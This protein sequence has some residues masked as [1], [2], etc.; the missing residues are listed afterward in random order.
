[1]AKVNPQLCAE[2]RE[3]RLQRTKILLLLLAAVAGCASDTPAV[4]ERPTGGTLVISVGGDPETL[5]PPLATTTP[6]QIIGDLVY[7][8]LAEIGDSL[9][10]TG[11]GGYRPRLASSW[12]WAADSMSIGFH[13][14]PRARWH[15][16]NPVRA[17]DV[18]F[19][20][21]IYS[22]PINGSP[23]A[24]A[25]T[26]IDSVVARDSLTA[27][28][29]F[30]S[31]SPNQF[32]D[33]VGTMYIL[34][35]H[36]LA[37]IR[38]ADLRTSSLA[39][40]PVGTGRFRFVKWAAAQS[41][42]LAADTGN[43]RG[44][45]NLDRVI[46]TIAPDFNTALARLL[47]GEADV[48]EQVP[49]V[50]LHEIQA[51]KSIAITLTPGLEYFFLQL[52]LRSPHDRRRPH[53]LF[54]DRALRRALTM[55]VDRNSV[56]RSAYG[57]LAE[58]A[59]GPTVRAYPTTDTTLVQIPFSPASAARTLDSLGWKDTN[60][61]GVRD[62]RD[63]PLEF[64]VEVPASSKARNAMAVIIQEQL[65]QVGVKMNIDRVDFAAFI[66]REEKRDFDAVLGGW[67]VEASPG[68]VRQTWGSIG[69]RQ[70]GGTNYG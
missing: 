70:A 8:H 18:A 65:R 1:M 62:R 57:P 12:T 14:D 63:G 33:A 60:G 28:F 22:N 21:Q 68:S 66:D 13:I 54:A 15:D 38:G 43:Y 31:R 45:P 55:A 67:H 39:R 34:P 52:N 16:G 64:D 53:R 40:A 3:T 27:V 37:G 41:I 5:L 44:R 47:G 17:T 23:F 36:V 69:A 20:Y 10:T 49:A 24:A 2:V 4:V 32:Y 30:K 42:Q 50:N 11:D 9:G 29:W 59:L 48:L 61:D 6:G 26:S 19:T 51:N 58:V 35:R 7:D 25:L 46:M 56:V